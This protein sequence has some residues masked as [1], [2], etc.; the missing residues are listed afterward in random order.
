MIDIIA[1]L[2]GAVYGY[3]KPGKEEKKV[4]LKKGAKIG[5]VLGAVLAVTNLLVG[6]GLLIA[7]ANLVWSVI[8]IVYLTI[9][10]VIGT[11]VGDWVE[12]KFK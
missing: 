12:V 8:A 3:V 11:L 2:L 5:A 4:L 1:L 7:T 6:G 10:F 9:M